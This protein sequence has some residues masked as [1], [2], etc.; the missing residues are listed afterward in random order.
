[1]KTITQ[2]IA[3]PGQPATSREGEG[4]IQGDFADLVQVTLSRTR[5]TVDTARVFRTVIAQRRPFE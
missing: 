4:S 5:A 1:M 2:V 3:R